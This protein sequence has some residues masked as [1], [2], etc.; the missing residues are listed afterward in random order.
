MNEVQSHFALEPCAKELLHFCHC[1]HLSM[2]V[3]GMGRCTKVCVFFLLIGPL[4]LNGY[5]ARV[6]VKNGNQNDASYK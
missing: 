3:L 6:V 2:F 4:N 1:F 5:M